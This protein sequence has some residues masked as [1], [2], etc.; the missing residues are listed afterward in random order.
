MVSNGQFYEFVRD[1]GYYN[2][3]WWSAD[4]WGWKC[5]RNIRHPT[6]WVSIVGLGLVPSLDRSASWFNTHVYLIPQVPTG[7]TGLQAFRLRNIFEEID[8]PWSNPVEVNFHEVSWCS[9]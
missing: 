9:F 7:P 3:E 4:G 2:R 6:F 5:F 8:M 1:G